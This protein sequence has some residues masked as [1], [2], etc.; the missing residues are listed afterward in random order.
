MTSY[1]EIFD[2]ALRRYDD[3]S[4]LNWPEEDLL[5]ELYSHMC[6]AIAN[7]PRIQAEVSERDVFDAADV[8]NTGF[9]NDLSDVTK[10][11]ITLGMKRAWLQPQVASSTLTLKSFSRREGGSQREH[12][13]GLM[14]LDESIRLEILRLLRDE[15]YVDSDYFN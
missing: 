11:V 2:L 7:I 1:K 4:F 3:P 8:E 15:S 5:N 10:A 6:M 9:H 12:L 14:E 13:R